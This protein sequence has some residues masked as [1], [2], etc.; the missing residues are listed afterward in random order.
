MKC[1][2]LK[3]PTL[4]FYFSDH[5]SSVQFG[6]AKTTADSERREF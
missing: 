6:F 3:T 1:I 5:S 4:D 2:V